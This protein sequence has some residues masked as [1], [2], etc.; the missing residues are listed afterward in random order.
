LVVSLRRCSKEHIRDVFMVIERPESVTVGAHD[1]KR[2]PDVGQVELDTAG[3]VLG[4]SRGVAVALERLHAS[5][6]HSPLTVGWFYNRI[7]RAIGDL[8]ASGIEVFTGD[9]ARQV[10]PCAW[11]DAPGRLYSITDKMTA[12][13]AIQEI[14]EQGEGASPTD[15][16]GEGTE[17]AHFFRFREIVEGREMVRKGSGAWVFEGSP[18]PFD[19]HGVYPMQDDPDT[20]NLAP[21]SSLRAASRWF[22]ETHAATLHSLQRVVDGEPQRLVDSIGL[23]FSLRQQA[24]HLMSM[25]LEPGSATTVGPSFQVA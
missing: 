2:A 6:R 16:I 5:T 19:P 7:A 9:P 21:D 24:Y 15:P 25:P 20:G 12:L 18:I 23:M 1:G 10:T 17:L 3:R 22:D 8:E 13:L 14:V 4:D 11:P